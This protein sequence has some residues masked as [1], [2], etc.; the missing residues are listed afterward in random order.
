MSM[1]AANPGQARTERVNLLVTPEE[2]RLIEA[3]AEAAGLTLSEVF[4]RGACAYTSE[5]ETSDM[6]AILRQL[7]EMADRLI[8]EIDANLDYIR[9]RDRAVG[10]EA[11]VRARAVK[12][13]EAN[14]GAWFSPPRRG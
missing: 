10:T 11:D 5:A 3:K 2:K 9:D 13:F 12:E 6:R 7:A 14:G 4:R 1:T 8:P